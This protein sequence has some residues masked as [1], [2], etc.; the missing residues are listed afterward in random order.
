MKTTN[1]YPFP[2]ERELKIEDFLPL[3]PHRL[4]SLWE[5]HEFFA[6]SF[7]LALDEL[8]DFKRRLIKM[9]LDESAQWPRRARPLES[10]VA[11]ILQFSE[12]LKLTETIGRCRRFGG[13]LLNST[14]VIPT[15]TRFL[16]TFTKEE[17]IS[18]IEGIEDSVRGELFR[19]KFVFIPT[20]KAEHFE[21][22]D[23]FGKTFHD[24]ASK[25]IN[26]EIKA[27]GNCLAAELN[28]AAIF[29][30]LRAAELGM[31]RL[32]KRLG[33]VVIREKKQ[34]KIDDATWTELVTGTKNQT[35]FSGDAIKKIIRTIQKEI[36]LDD[37]EWDELIIAI[38]EKVETEKALK[39]Q[40]RKIK[41]YFK[42]YE[43]LA[44]QFD[45]MKNDRNNIM[46]THGENTPDEAKVVLGRVKDF[47]LKLAKRISLK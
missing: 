45:H 3:R 28:T 18:E 30:F 16:K 29:H 22:D 27:A 42:E 32:A 20:D 35:N 47:M 24:S 39:P 2:E 11:L 13:Q 25:E 26:F 46:H 31:R 23:L 37:A 15:T 40:A 36:K 19:E 4:I 38:R 21:R 7:V 8:A 6:C 44:Q 17:L 43:R 41:K 10:A 1:C 14:R 34:I 33:V 9:N 12:E 5:M